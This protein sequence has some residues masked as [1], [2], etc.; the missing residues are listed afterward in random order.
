MADTLFHSYSQ[1]GEDVVLWRALRDVGLGRYIDVG[2]NDP[3][4]YSISM[5]FYER[6]WSGITVEPDPEFAD[7][8]ARSRPRDVLVRAAAADRDGDEIRFYVVDGTGLST[9][10]HELA[11]RHEQAGYPFHDITVGTRTLDSILDEQ[12]WQDL[13]I[14]FMTVDVEGAEAAVLRGVDLAKHRPWVLVVESTAPLSTVSTTDQWE[15]R[16]LEA[17]YQKTLFDGLS[18]FYVADERADTLFDKLSVPACPLDDYMGWEYWTTLEELQAAR[19]E[20]ARLRSETAHWRSTASRRWATTLARTA[21]LDETQER[22][23]RMTEAYQEMGGLHHDRFYEVAALRQ[24]L[25]QMRG[26]KSWQLTEPLRRIRTK[27]PI[28]LPK[29]RG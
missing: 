4:K 25:E 3:R 6:G 5:A 24:E 13:D 28:P 23:R 29:R 22:L 19:E 12:G 18:T 14:H 7:R 26:S 8:Q 21:E 9:T 15:S 10:D 1:N 16:V 27:L 11:M 2:A 17:G 20:I